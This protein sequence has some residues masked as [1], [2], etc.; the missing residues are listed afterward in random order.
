MLVSYYGSAVPSLLEHAPQV[1]MPSLHHF[2]WADSYI[3]A[4]TV[5]RVRAAVCQNPATRFETYEGAGHAFDNPRPEFHHAQASARAW[6]TTAE[7]LAE[8]L[9][10]GRAHVRP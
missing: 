4:D 6:H 2:G 9:P 1:D 7:F 3:D 10:V 5:V 8:H